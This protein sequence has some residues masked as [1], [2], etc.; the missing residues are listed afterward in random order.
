MNWH[1]FL[2]A[3][4]VIGGAASGPSALDAAAASEP[5]IVWGSLALIAA[6]SL[7]ALL[8]VLGFQAALGSAKGLRWNWL[9]LLYG[10]VYC[11]VSG[12]A[13]LVVA[14]RGPG[15]APHSFVIFV[16]GVGMLCGL[17]IARL[18]FR[19]RFGGGPDILP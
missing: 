10:A 4:A 1:R 6:G 15:L 9:F 5:P 18:A 13:A 14:V 3:A 8:L 11:T 7:V 17:G 19:R 2:L 16:L 12:M